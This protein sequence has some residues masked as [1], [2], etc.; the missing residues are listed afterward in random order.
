MC[1]RLTVTF[2]LYGE[3]YTGTIHHETTIEGYQYGISL[4]RAFQLLRSENFNNYVSAIGC[5]AV[6]IYCKGNEDD[7]SSGSR[8][9]V[10]ALVR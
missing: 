8:V 1:S 10:F 7:L 5:T 2:K 3:S 6:A 4:D 9:M